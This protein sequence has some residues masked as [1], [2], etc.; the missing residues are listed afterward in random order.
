MRIAILTRLRKVLKMFD[1][2]DYLIFIYAG[3]TALLSE[4]VLKIVLPNTPAP[5]TRRR[6]GGICSIVIGFIITGS[7][8][9]YLGY[10]LVRIL[11]RSLL[12][13]A[14]SNFAYDYAKTILGEVFTKKI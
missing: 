5:I 12:T 9:I 8:G 14:F 4:F 1:K 7:H 2:I 13:I 6:I 11:Y 3:A 10:P